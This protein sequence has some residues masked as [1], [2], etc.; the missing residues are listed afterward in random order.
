MKKSNVFGDLVGFRVYYSLAISIAI[1]FS[2][3]DLRLAALIIS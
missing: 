3:S 1:G 2:V